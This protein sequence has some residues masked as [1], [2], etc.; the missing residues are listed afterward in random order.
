MVLSSVIV[1]LL[2][3]YGLF[4][5]KKGKWPGKLLLYAFL[6]VWKERIGRTFDNEGRLI[7]G[8]KFSFIC[9]L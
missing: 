6:I 5:L 9:I 3:W 7:Q 2:G 8:L 4:L 1:T